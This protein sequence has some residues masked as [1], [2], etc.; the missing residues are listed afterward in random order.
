MWLECDEVVG[1]ARR[2]L[3]GQLGVVEVRFDPGFGE[4]APMR[5]V[6]ELSGLGLSAEDLA[7][8]GLGSEQ[9]VQCSF[10]L[11]E[12]AVFGMEADLQGHALDPVD[13]AP[14]QD[15]GL[16]VRPGGF[17]GTE[18]DLDAAPMCAGAVLA[19]VIGQQRPHDI[20]DLVEQRNLHDRSLAW[21]RRSS[22]PDPR[23]A[24]VTTAPARHLR[25]QN[26]GGAMG[27][28]MTNATLS[29]RFALMCRNITPLRGLEPVAT[30]EEIRAAALQFVRK[31]G[32]LSSVSAANQDVVDRAVDD[33]SATVERLL[34]ELPPRKAPPKTEPPLRRI[35]A[36]KAAAASG[37]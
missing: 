32:G 18:P 23:S 2:D 27:A 26:P 20:V 3:E 17:L 21:R 30:E 7:P 37:A 34:E 19:Q 8:V 22:Q 6:E 15:L 12:V 9:R 1:Q 36:K 25:W 10:V 28:P 31:V 35:A 24:S 16:E 29:G 14:A 4:S 5:C 13:M 33:I 11:F